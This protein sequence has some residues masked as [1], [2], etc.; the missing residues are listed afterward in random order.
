M[1]WDDHRSSCQTTFVPQKTKR[2]YW[3]SAAITN[4]VMHEQISI[5][6]FNF[7][8]AYAV[9]GHGRLSHH[10]F[11]EGQGT[12]WTGHQSVNQR[13]NAYTQGGRIYRGNLEHVNSTETP[14]KAILLWGDSDKHWATMRKYVHVYWHVCIMSLSFSVY[15]ATVFSS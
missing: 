14:Q 8:T 3:L 10:A 4:V 12:P 7:Y 11:H 15:I 13:A 5:H 2:R 9:Q 6:T 1:K